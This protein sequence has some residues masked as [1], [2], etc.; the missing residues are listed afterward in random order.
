MKYVAGDGYV[1]YPAT[2]DRRA[3]IVP[4]LVVIFIVAFIAAVFTITLSA[5]SDRP[6]ARREGCSCPAPTTA[7]A[8]SQLD[9]GIPA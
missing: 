2:W 8:H 3:S 6:A 4:L 9:I 5:Y 7:F 1:I